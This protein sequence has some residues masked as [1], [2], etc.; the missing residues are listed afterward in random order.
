MRWAGFDNLIYMG[1]GFFFFFFWDERYRGSGHL[2]HLIM[3]STAFELDQL[4]V[5]VIFLKKL[6]F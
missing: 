6:H 5:A 2:A 3:F 4:F 1:V